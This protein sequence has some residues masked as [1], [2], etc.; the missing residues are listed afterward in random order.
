MWGVRICHRFQ[1]IVNI[2]GGPPHCIW[3]IS[4]VKRWNFGLNFEILHHFNFASPTFE[5]DW[6]V[7]RIVRDHWFH[8]YHYHSS[9]FILFC[10]CHIKDRYWTITYY[11][12]III[13]QYPTY[14]P[15]LIIT[16]T[17]CSLHLR[18]AKQRISWRWTCIYTLWMVHI[19]S[20]VMLGNREEWNFVR[21]VNE[22]YHNG[23]LFIYLYSP[24]H[25]YVHIEV[26][27]LPLS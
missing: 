14:I 25:V 4:N 6:F 20:G 11:H 15:H 2:G 22:C 13:G 9:V 24:H 7:V 18:T 5:I 19:C 3:F 27:V 23:P 8:D 12:R 1:A 17:H 10:F 21:K 16:N 26:S